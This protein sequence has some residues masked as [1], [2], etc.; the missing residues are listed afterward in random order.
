LLLV[1]QDETARFLKTRINQEVNKSLTSK[2]INMNYKASLN[3]N[4]QLDQKNRNKSI[5]EIESSLQSLDPT[6]IR[7][8][9][10]LISYQNKGYKSI[11]P[12]QAKM[13]NYFGR[14]REWVNKC[15]ARLE[16]EGFIS[17]IQR[18]NNSCIYFLPEYF[19]IRE[20]R[21][22]LYPILKS[23]RFISP[24]FLM[25][26]LVI[27][28]R[29]QADFTLYKKGYIYNPGLNRETM[30]CNSNSV[31]NLASKSKS[32]PGSSLESMTLKSK[33]SNSGAVVMETEIY[34]LIKSLS[35][36]NLSLLGQVKLMA[37]PEEAIR[38]NIKKAKDSPNINNR[39]TY[40]LALCG[41][42]CRAKEI[43]LNLALVTELMKKYHLTGREDFINKA[44][45]PAQEHSHGSYPTVATTDKQAHAPSLEENKNSSIKREDY[46]AERPTQGP[47]SLFPGIPDKVLDGDEALLAKIE[48]ELR[49]PHI[50]AFKKELCEEQK[51]IIRKRIFLRNSEPI[52][53][54]DKTLPP[55]P[56][57]WSKD[58]QWH[59]DWFNTYK[60]DPLIAK[61]PQ[62]VAMVDKMIAEGPAGQHAL[63]GGL[64]SFLKSV[65]K[66]LNPGKIPTNI[67]LSMLDDQGKTISQ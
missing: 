67:E 66:E 4:Q 59:M 9:D 6:S 27:Q 53:V 34:P 51:E 64:L 2:L 65:F 28:P 36:L 10:Y 33:S 50:N 57:Q 49:N 45:L 12:S 11:Y 21:A 5:L 7:V 58:Q 23:L 47:R 1:R 43:E 41:I 22:K 60:G 24:F 35:F 40:L 15:V 14:S 29:E 39:Y 3:K 32:N 18:F 44:P 46:D 62:V 19:S 48:E 37:Y 25:M 55:A 8:I 63:S 31:I 52:F 56:S 54:E 17:H 16:K 30:K 20:V 61:H 13:A 38:A 26:D 42:Y